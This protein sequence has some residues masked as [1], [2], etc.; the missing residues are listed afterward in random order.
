MFLELCYYAVFSFLCLILRFLCLWFASDLTKAMGEGVEG[1]LPVTLGWDL[2]LEGLD[3]LPFLPAFLGLRGP[4]EP[5]RA[6][7]EG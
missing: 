4:S 7:G 3:A 5:R 1:E 6:G 2:A